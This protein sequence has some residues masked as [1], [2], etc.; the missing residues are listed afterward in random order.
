MKKKLKHG[1]IIVFHLRDDEYIYEVHNIERG[2]DKDCGLFLDI[3]GGVLPNYVIFED[4]DLDAKD[5]AEKHYGYPIIT[6]DWPEAKR[7][8][9]DALQRLI[10]ALHMECNIQNLKYHTKDES[11]QEW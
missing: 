11:P 1:K 8:D 6:G 9:F 2:D 10:N 5:F 7:N 3:K 4:L